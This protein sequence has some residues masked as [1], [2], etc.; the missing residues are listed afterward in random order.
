MEDNKYT[1]AELLALA[2]ATLKRREKQ[3]RNQ[4]RWREK[5]KQN[6]KATMTL[7]VPANRIEEIKMVVVAMSKEEAGTFVLCKSIEKDGKKI[8]D[9]ITPKIELK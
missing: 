7:T 5:L 6:G 2:E 4:A 8:W 3:A 9:I 1:K